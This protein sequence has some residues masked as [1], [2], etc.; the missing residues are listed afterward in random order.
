[1]LTHF[2][3]TLLSTLTDAHAANRT[4]AGLA[5]PNQLW[6]PMAGFTG[7]STSISSYYTWTPHPVIPTPD[8]PPIYNVPFDFIPN[9]WGCTDDKINE[10]ND[11]L[12]GNFS[13]VKLT[14]S[15]EI[16]GFN[17]PDLPGQANCSPERAAEVWQSTLEP[18][19]KQGYRIG[20]PAVSGGPAGKAWMQRWFEV[21]DGG[22][23]PDFVAVH[24]VCSAFPRTMGCIDNSTTSTRETL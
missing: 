21:C 19:K 6:V 17:E 9:L 14:P 22:C 2:V 15:R 20:S 13:N 11:A 16:L 4:A 3:L 7:P 10:F 5:W 24:W 18:L 12:R 23:D 1:M 8:L